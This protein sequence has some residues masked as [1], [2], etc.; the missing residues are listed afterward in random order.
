M[1]FYEASRESESGGH[2]FY[3]FK[4]LEYVNIKTSYG[5]PWRLREILK[6]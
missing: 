6:F 2:F 1:G 3:S 5:I 4:Y